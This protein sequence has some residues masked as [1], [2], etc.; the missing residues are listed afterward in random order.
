MWKTY[1]KKINKYKAYYPVVI[2]IFDKIKHKGVEPARESENHILDTVVR[3]TFSR[4]WHL[5]EV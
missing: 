2:I 5:N 1:T 3:K 4:N